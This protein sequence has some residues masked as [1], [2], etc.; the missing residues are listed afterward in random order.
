MGLNAILARIMKLAE[1]D[2]LKKAQAE[3]KRR[4]GGGSAHTAAASSTSTTA[5]KKVEE[6]VEDV[7]AEVVPAVTAPTTVVSS[8]PAPLQTPSTQNAVQHTQYTLPPF[9]LVK[10]NLDKAVQTQ[11]AQVAT[12]KLIE[13]ALSKSIEDKRALYSESDV[14]ET[15]DV[16]N[17]G[18]LNINGNTQYKV[19]TVTA[20]DYKKVS[21]GLANGT[22]E[23]WLIEDGDSIKS[24]KYANRVVENGSVTTAVNVIGADRL[25]GISEDDKCVIYDPATQKFYRYAQSDDVYEKQRTIE[26]YTTQMSEYTNDYVNNAV[27]KFEATITQLDAVLQPLVDKAET[28]GLTDEE[29]ALF[30]A[31]WE[32]R[33]AVVTEANTAYDTYATNYT[34]VLEKYNAANSD[35]NGMGITGREVEQYYALNNLKI[36]YDNIRK[37]MG[38]DADRALLTSTYGAVNMPQS[39]IDTLNTLATRISNVTQ[40]TVYMNEDYMNALNN[41][42]D[43]IRT[44]LA[45][46]E[47]EA[48]IYAEFDSTTQVN[49]LL[50]VLK[51]AISRAAWGQFEDTT[52][53]EDLA[54]AISYKTTSILKV[55]SEEDATASKVIG[56]IKNSVLTELGETM[57]ITN[58]FKPFIAGSNNY[59]YGNFDD[60]EL[61]AFIITQA[62]KEWDELGADAKSFWEPAAGAH[63]A[64]RDGVAEYAGWVS[65]KS[66]LGAYGETPNFDYI[67]AAAPEDRSAGM[68]VATMLMDIVFDP[69]TWVD[70]TKAAAKAGAVAGALDGN[71]DTLLSKQYKLW[72]DAGATIIDEAALGLE[73]AAKLA[74]DMAAAGT[75]AIVRNATTDQN[76]I[77]A[78]RNAIKKVYDAGGGEQLMRDALTNASTKSTEA[79]FKKALGKKSDTVATYLK[80]IDALDD[81]AKTAHLDALDAFTRNA[82]QTTIENMATVAKTDGDVMAKLIYQTPKIV[83][84]MHTL[85]NIESVLNKTLLSV[86]AP[87]LAVPVA[88]TRG[89]KKLLAKTTNLALSKL[90]ADSVGSIT[91]KLAG[92]AD[93]THVYNH[94][95]VETVKELT[96]E[97]SVLYANAGHSSESYKFFKELEENS[98]K[99]YADYLLANDL[100]PIKSIL[101]DTVYDPVT[102]IKA[103][104]DWAAKQGYESF[105][106]CVKDIEKNIGFFIDRSD[107]AKA[108]YSEFQRLYRSAIADKNIYGTRQLIDNVYRTGLNNIAEQLNHTMIGTN[109]IGQ[110]QNMHTTVQLM[111]DQFVDMITDVTKGDY[112]HAANNV[113]NAIK[114]YGDHYDA[115]ADALNK[116]VQEF[117]ELSNKYVDGLNAHIGKIKTANYVHS[118]PEEYIS[119]L[120]DKK[121]TLRRTQQNSVAE[122]IRKEL[123]KHQGLNIDVA[124]IQKNLVHESYKDIL[125]DEAGE[126]DVERLRRVYQVQLDKYTSALQWTSDEAMCKIVDD[127]LDI[128]TDVNCALRNLET[129]IQVALSKYDLAEEYVELLQRQLTD[130]N[131]F[132]DQ[133]ARQKHTRL[134]FDNF[135][136]AAAAN[137]V[138]AKQVNAVLDSMAGD[139]TRRIN[140][141][142]VAYMETQNQKHIDNIVDSIVDDATEY[143]RE[144]SDIPVD[145]LWHK[146]CNT[147][148]TADNVQRIAEEAKR[149]VPVD[150]QFIDVYYSTAGTIR[151]ADP[152]IIS[153]KVDDAV[154]TFR[155]ADS[156]FMLHDSHAYKMYGKNCTEITE[157]YAKVC[158]S[159]PGLSKLE[160]AQ[161]IQRYMLQLNKQATDQGKQLRFIG[162]NNGAAT[163][164]SDKFIKDFFIGNNIGVR[165]NSTVDVAEVIRR[166]GGM[167]YLPNE[168]VAA[169]RKSITDTLATA[170]TNK[171][172]HGASGALIM[173]AEVPFVASTDRLSTTVEHIKAFMGDYSQ[174]AQ[175]VL[176]PLFDGVNRTKGII[177]NSRKILGGDDMGK[178]LSEREIAE[179]I[180]TASLGKSR[181]TRIDN[182]RALYGTMSDVKHASSGSFGLRKTL[183]MNLVAEWF[184]ED[185]LARLIKAQD[186]EVVIATRIEDLTQLTKGLDYHYQLVSNPELLD[187]IGVDAFREVYNVAITL[188]QHHPKMVGSRVAEI[189]CEL[190]LNTAQDYFSA[191]MYLQKKY[192]GMF[193]DHQD[194]Y[195]Q[196]RNLATKDVLHSKTW[197]DALCAIGINT[198]DELVFNSTHTI[199]RYGTAVNVVETKYATINEQ[200]VRTR[201]AMRDAELAAQQA[202]SLG[203]LL[204]LKDAAYRKGNY[205]TAEEHIQYELFSRAY[206]PYL[207]LVEFV[208]YYSPNN[209]AVKYVL[210]SDASPI[211]KA[212][213]IAEFDKDIANKMRAIKQTSDAHRH[214]AVAAA[215][216]LSNEDFE[217]YV[218]R[219]C[220]NALVID[221]NADIFQKELGILLGKRLKEITDSTG[222]VV[223]KFTKLDANGNARELIRVYKNLDGH[224]MDELLTSVWDADV[225]LIDAYH[226]AF[227]RHARQY[228][229]NTL[230][231]LDVYQEFYNYTEQM[232]EYMPERYFG[233]TMDVLT[234]D[235]FAALQADF[236]EVAHLKA[237]RIK[238]W[239]DESYNCSVWGDVTT[240]RLYNG[241]ASDKLL[242]NM[243]RGLHHVQHKMEAVANVMNMFN[244]SSQ[245]LRSMVYAAG[246]ENASWKTIKQQ[247]ES[248][249]YVLAVI[250]PTATGSYVATKMP[251]DSARDYKKYMKDTTVVCLENS[252]FNHINA[253][254]TKRNSLA[255]YDKLHCNTVVGNMADMYKTWVDTVRSARITGALFL[256]NFKGS[257]INNIIDSTIKGFNDSG[258]NFLK[259]VGNAIEYQ[260][261]YDEVCAAIAEKYYDVNSNNIMKYFSEVTDTVI[262][263]E[264]F[265]KLHVLNRLASSDSSVIYDVIKN[266]ELPKMRK[267]LKEGTQYT[268]DELK[269]VM[270]IFNSVHAK[271]KYANI[272]GELKYTVQTEMYEAALEQ[273]NKVYTPAQAIELAELF[274]HYTPTAITWGQKLENVP[275]I[276]ALIKTNAKT[277]SD[278]ET[279]TRTAMYLAYVDEMGESVNKAE[280]AI[281]RAQFDYSNRPGIL[282][283]IEKLLPFSTFKVYNAN[284]WMNEATKK[285]STMKNITRLS[286]AT[287]STYDAQEIA[288]IIRNQ[289]ITEMM[290]NQQQDTAEEDDTNKLQKWWNNSIVG[291]KGIPATYAQGLH[292]GDNHIL[293]IDNSFM[294]A[295]TLAG[296]L[297]YAPKQIKDGQLPTIIA[298]SVYSPLATL[299][300]F[301]ADYR[302]GDKINPTDVTYGNNPEGAV[303]AQGWALSNIHDIINLVPAYGALTNM[304]LTHIKNGC[305]NIA[306][307]KAM[308]CDETLRDA[309]M[310]KIFESMI[311]GAGIILPSFVGITYDP[312]TYFEREV[313]LNWSDNTNPAFWTTRINPETG[314]YYT[315]EEAEAAVEEYRATHQYVYGVSNIPSFMGKDP[316]TYINYSAMFIK[317]GFDEEDVKNNI[318]QLLS[319]LYGG[320]FEQDAATNGVFFNADGKGGTY[321]NSAL[322]NDTLAALAA[323]G[324]SIEEAIACMKSEK[325]YNP[326]T[327]Q[328][329][330]DTDLYKEIANS[331]F[332][333]V[334]EHLPEYMRYDK[335]QYSQLMAYWKSTGLTTQ[336]AWMMMQSENGFIDEQG[337]YRVLTSA[338]AE[339]YTKQLNDDYY[340]FTD[341]LPDW[342]KYETGAATRTVNYLMEQGMSKEAAYKYIISNN[343]Y[344][345][346]DGKQHYFSQEESAAKTEASSK[347]FEEYYSA[348]P[349]YIKYEKGAYS[350]TL[351]YLKNVE[352]VDT[353]TAK[354][355]IGNGAYLTVDGR[356]IDCTALQRGYT[357]ESKKKWVNYLSDEEW[358]TYYQ[359]LPNY[360]KYEKGAF[361]RTYAALKELGFDYETCLSLIKQGAYLMPADVNSTALRLDSAKVPANAVTDINTLLQAYGNQAL[362][363]EDVAYTLVNCTELVRMNVRGSNYSNRAYN[364][365][366][367][368][369][370]KANS[371]NLYSKRRYAPAPKIKRAVR[372]YTKG[373]Y[374]PNPYVT[375]KSY[376][377][378]YSK[379]NVLAGASYGARKVYK[380]TLGYNPVRQS[381]SIKSAYP[382]AYRNI[383]YSNRRNLYKDLYAKYGTS[384]IVMRANA[385]NS[386]SNACITRLRRNEIQNRMRYANRRS[387]F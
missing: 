345:D 385:A 9:T 179:F 378:T 175:R 13:S 132:I 351:E 83:G 309:Y 220:M 77:K 6:V 353:A 354:Q 106:L 331:A 338:Q 10:R 367:Q 316:A 174:D 278:A 332:L 143:L 15:Y 152:H 301:L 138:E 293:K 342:Y 68:T 356:L 282:N 308:M 69:G 313:G 165:W 386:Y 346:E 314:T 64:G 53:L 287:D 17:T 267:L 12:N 169:I 219:N 123:Q 74:K 299:W 163:T 58:V 191:L 129:E 228:T 306:D 57:D 382:A 14:R 254:L 171:Y 20:V 212:G 29:Y 168:A 238:K 286:R 93:A 366:V 359:S 239:F 156:P 328:F 55:A 23:V 26:A 140:Y 98:L 97:I 381:L 182:M 28:T 133:C 48:S 303:D 264:M 242:D 121:V 243:G 319:Q 269:N 126:L 214:A 104:D 185:A 190:N 336:Q 61:N 295:I 114:E 218:V 167:E 211:A 2:R 275:V 229:D 368:Y 178:L 184:N 288:T 3:E 250:K 372:H 118:A 67:N 40:N 103:L 348:L 41:Y 240:Q 187:A 324:Y 231:E 11:Q 18:G 235:T 204:D 274:Y 260:R 176:N 370:A 320:G 149:V 99:A 365:Y 119:N 95:V 198:A 113:I 323:K 100:T 202:E 290:R 122:G 252:V 329:V 283:S 170:R 379:V 85:D 205:L 89:I 76:I 376:S 281:I 24:T 225:P 34:A 200:V 261:S 88:A 35:L 87:V 49:S 310:H 257:G 164:E 172:L 183:D 294:D 73:D 42:A 125:F 60:P 189:L 280:Q 78:Y 373:S 347:E 62:Q 101:T 94:N 146:Q 277:F 206:Q 33:Q 335:D 159:I 194:V 222:L 344:V 59:V 199:H 284:Y 1:E 124:E 380:V 259:Y 289:H 312:T 177:D 387:N 207:N 369:T 30:Q 217:T 265:T 90:A 266:N 150:D 91:K 357:A 209:D 325:W 51:R 253:A 111:R 7:V 291:Y 115:T 232:A 16:A 296:N 272:P 251:L 307:F 304:V 337:R 355:I 154:S 142:A 248:R 317:W 350:R 38:T 339:Q 32:E 300:N 81:A 45:A 213:K 247:L 80:G 237:G 135:E 210:N 127:V 216:S 86:A 137:G 134:L 315:M 145:Y 193:P 256:S 340:E 203:T 173:D 383:V 19:N 166:A 349:N 285:Y 180:S 21:E 36:A 258:S 226:G 318:G 197:Y 227:V 109:K 384:R 181:K 27:T 46:Y 108:M 361:K 360:I 70:L 245:S 377:S 39:D 262:D 50:D 105:K 5:P 230:Y 147:V 92:I 236:P 112:V 321:L 305:A 364:N 157:E 358:N 279:R 234:Q 255:L 326:Y 110:L 31:T 82:T 8:I 79:M 297:W 221:P 362:M 333:D 4:N 343:F 151:G 270:N 107:S 130:I 271:R 63:T 75:P 334:Y 37:G 102:R 327:G 363:Q 246:V 43:N 128:N 263:Q 72:E 65:F 298:D 158:E 244:N 71:V 139:K 311:D 223:E 292:I 375:N 44:E 160:Y 195:K 241:Y 302:R 371:T 276:G 192:S 66:W 84:T 268:D 249:G 233:S 352:G 22:F 148:N 341:A 196:L 120:A 161:Q 208:N 188:L 25:N 215:L 52:V 162:F 131:E 116:V 224:N 47:Q 330:T 201:A 273:L 144:I 54:E 141:N 155:N 186:N 153:F 96:D 322:I 56:A 117:T 374:T 136:K